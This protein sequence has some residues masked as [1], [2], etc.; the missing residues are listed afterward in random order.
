LRSKQSDCLWEMEM[1]LWQQSFALHVVVQKKRPFYRVVVADKRAARDGAF[2][3]KLGIF[4]PLLAK[5]NEQRLVVNTERA[6]HW[7]SVG[8]KPS[9]RVQK[10]LASLEIMDAPSYAGK[11]EKKRR[12]A[13]KLTRKEKA[14]QA[15]AEAKEAAEA[16]AKAAAEAPAEEAPAEPAEAEDAAKTEESAA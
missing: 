11:P 3:E 4:N 8:A 13:D 12:N 7:L 2:I 1:Y 9:E 14:A 6:K 16:E 10:L 15:E 5:D